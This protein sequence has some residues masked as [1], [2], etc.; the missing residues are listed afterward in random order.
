MAQRLTAVKT[1]RAVG[2]ATQ[3]REVTAIH[4]Q[5][6]ARNDTFDA[7]AQRR[8]RPLDRGNVLC[9]R[10]EQDHRDFATGG[11]FVFSIERAELQCETFALMQ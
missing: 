2:V 6:G 11:T 1:F 10:I 5:L 3:E 8:V 9:L 4:H 7:L